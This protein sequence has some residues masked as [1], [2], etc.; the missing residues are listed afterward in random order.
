LNVT[1]NR[2]AGRVVGPDV[3]V[4]GGRVSDVA[5]ADVVAVPIGPGDDAG[6][7]GP[8]VADVVGG[9]GIDL[10]ALLARE[11]VKADAGEVFAVPVT[12]ADTGVAQ[13]L[14][15]GV[16]DRSPQAFRRA[17][18]ALARRV[19][20]RSHLVTSV[21]E[22]ENA[23]AVRAFA[24]GLV[25]GSYMF[26]LR[27]SKDEQTAVE[28][29]TLVVR[30]PEAREQALQRGLVTGAAVWLARD[31]ANMPSDTKTPEWLARQA[32]RVART[33]GLDVRVW[34]ER[35]LAGSGFG[36]ILAVGSGSSRPPRLIQLS[37]QPAAGNERTRQVVLVGK[38]ITFDSG[39]LSLKPRE[40][41][42][43]MK[44]DMAGGAAVIAVLGALRS[45]GV[46]TRVTGLVAAAENLPSGSAMRPG[47][48]LRQYGGRTVEVLNTDAEGR[49]VLAD[50]LSYA[51][52]E[53]DP[54]VVVDIA[55]L[56]GSATTAL[57]RRVGALFA[58]DER[59]ASALL[60]AGEASGDRLWRMPL[61]EEYRPA[62]DSPVADLA[63][64]SHDPKVQGG[65]I[66]A[67]LFLREFVG[68]R[69]WAHLDIAGPG[70]VDFEEHEITKGGTGFGVR[71]LLHW[72]LGMRG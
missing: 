34:D 17:G 18:A 30:R 1:L 9:M 23:E 54:D 15:A 56:T 26:S 12:R 37:Y 4:V 38:G 67:A 51:D 65:A 48:V 55:T 53:L 8:R 52:R 33:A 57:S 42:V 44:A 24:E 32:R 49:L 70:K 39:G 50:A 71:V 21:V 36:G 7:A 40:A 3:R 29:V 59:L 43:P 35:Q 61:V 68:S 45:L 2:N 22:R 47:D 64:V 13:L 46:A 41:M 25:L 11:K 69:P 62:L 58:T 5:G 16:G 6:Q 60:A 14:L 66:T 72:L 31:L 28:R 63:N 10:A 27:T 20:T 19:K